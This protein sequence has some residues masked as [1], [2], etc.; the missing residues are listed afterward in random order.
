VITGYA[1]YILW[2]WWSGVKPNPIFCSTVGT[3]FKL[4][5]SYLPFSHFTRRAGIGE[6]NGNSSGYESSNPLSFRL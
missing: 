3:G 4:N 5:P 6:G 1:S 2:N